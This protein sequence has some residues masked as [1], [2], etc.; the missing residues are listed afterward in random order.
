M[1]VIQE[2]A[3]VFSSRGRHAI[4]GC[5]WSSGVCSSDLEGAARG[6]AGRRRRDPAGEDAAGGVGHLPDEVRFEDAGVA[7]DREWALD[8]RVRERLA[9][10]DQAARRN[11]R[12]RGRWWRW[13]GA[14]RW[15]RHDGWTR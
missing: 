12:G 15:R 9:H 1:A 2:E 10:D 7:T 8:A 14:R 3:K 11:E 5:D 4:F 6:R 13:G